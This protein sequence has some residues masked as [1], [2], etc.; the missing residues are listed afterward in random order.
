MAEKIAVIDYDAGNLRNVEKAFLYLGKNVI[1]TDSKEEILSA[2]HVVL[3]GV[4]S[5]G[6]CMGSIRRKG[7]DTVIKSVIENKTPF[8]GIC[9]GMQL[10]FDSSEESPEAEGLGILKG[11]I[12]KIPDCGLK[13]PHMGWNDIECKGRLFEGLDKPFVYFV[14]SYYLEAEDPSIVSAT[15]EYGIKIQVAAEKDNIFAAQFHPEKSGTD[16]LQMLKNF[17]ETRREDYVR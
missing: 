17:A 1:V 16:G 15:T 4:G 7:L 10:L 8:L 5:F 12:K 3:P 9:L 13:I 6:D 14:H 11:K 2:S